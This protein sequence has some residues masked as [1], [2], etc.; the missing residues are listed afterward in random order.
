M[1]RIKEFKTFTNEMLNYDQFDIV[2][3]E[4][5]QG[6]K[7]GDVFRFDDNDY[8]Y[9]IGQII[10][11][12][13]KN[14]NENGLVEYWPEKTPVANPRMFP[15]KSVLDI[16]EANDY[17]I[18]TLKKS[19]E[20]LSLSWSSQQSAAILKCRIVDIYSGYNKLKYI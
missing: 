16:Q 10:N 2:P 18:I 14:P 19:N 15:L 6:L 1:K 3:E 5:C 17:K 20:S 12:K 8:M 4:Y 11:F 7:P 9:V 13:H